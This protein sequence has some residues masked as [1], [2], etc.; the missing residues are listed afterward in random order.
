M[1]KPPI[2]ER[3]TT[4]DTTSDLVIGLHSLRRQWRNFFIPYLCH[5]FSRPP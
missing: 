3:S 4:N 5:L 2:G 1:A